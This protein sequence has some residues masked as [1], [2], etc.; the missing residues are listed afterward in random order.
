MSAGPHFI[1]HEP[2]K[3]GRILRSLIE[4]AGGRPARRSPKPRPA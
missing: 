2:Q 3:L 1:R 4:S